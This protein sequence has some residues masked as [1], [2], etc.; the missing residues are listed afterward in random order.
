MV[1]PNSAAMTNEPWFDV[2]CMQEEESEFLPPANAVARKL[3]FSV[4]FV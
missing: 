4:V 2:T 3:M 1:S